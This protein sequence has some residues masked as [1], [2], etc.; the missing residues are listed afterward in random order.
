MAASNARDAT[1]CCALGRA[2]GAPASCWLARGPAASAGKACAKALCK[3]TSHKG[4]RQATVSASHSA[5]QARC[6]PLDKDVVAQVG[7]EVRVL[8][9]ILLLLV[10]VRRW[11][12]LPMGGARRGPTLGR[13]AHNELQNSHTLAHTASISRRGP[14][15]RPRPDHA[16]FQCLCSLAPCYNI[17]PP[18][19]LSNGISNPKGS[20][21]HEYFVVWSK[22]K[23]AGHRDMHEDIHC[24]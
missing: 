22:G 13:T 21:R 9:S 7:V 20:N 14:T 15:R 5:P 6:A 16:A 12:K 11:V 4:S 18:A 17:R 24:A 23:A 2:S 8:L 19:A 3:Q 10:L 1:A